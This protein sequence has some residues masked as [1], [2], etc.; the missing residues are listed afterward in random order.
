M[1]QAARSVHPTRL[2]EFVWV[3]NHLQG[4]NTPQLH[5]NILGWLEQAWAKGERELALLVFRDAGKSTLVGLFCAWALTRDPD[6]RILVLAADHQ[7]AKKM[8]RNVKRIIERHPLAKQL[9]PA[10]GGQWAADQFTVRR[11]RELRDPSM[12]AKGLGANV[13]GS[14]ADL[15]ICDDVEVP[16]TCD[17][18]NKREEL[19]TRLREIDYVLTPQGTQLYIGTP[20]TRESIY[21]EDSEAAFL[22][23]F[24]RLELPILDARGRS[25]WP[26]RFPPEKIEAIRRRSGPAKF[27]SQMLLRPTSNEEGRLDPGRLVMYGEELAYQE[28]NGAASLRLGSTRLVSASCWWDPAYGAPG[29]GDSSVI[30]AVFSDEDGRA[31]LHRVEYLTHDGSAGEADEA[32][33]LCRK[34]AAFARALHLPAV[35]VEING[36][37][38]FLPGLLR[39]AMAETRT[40]CAVIETTSRKP[41]AVR[42]IEAFDARLAAGAIWTHASVFKGPFISEMREW[43]PAKAG[44]RDDGLDAVAGCLLSEPVRINARL[45][46]DGLPAR[47]NWQ[48]AQTPRAAQTDFTP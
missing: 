31:Y 40:P 25:R 28:A 14:R 17:T 29:K 39:R 44:A 9:K 11:R 15:V 43:R 45:S 24:K 3:W 26:E 20:H 5:R 46:Q 33:Q 12:I 35:T 36:I 7:L 41:K 37:G 8:V 22:L 19:R 42:I 4:M 21:A 32:T 48:G 6:L 2:L 23:G 30:A 1:T 16:R 34:V 18:P 10:R 27:A 47:P 13:T 38:R